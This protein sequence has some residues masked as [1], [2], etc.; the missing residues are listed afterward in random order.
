[1]H[2]K[3]AIYLTVLSVVIAGPV[4]VLLFIYPGFL[5]VPAHCDPSYEPSV[6]LSGHRFCAEMIPIA[7]PA[8]CE[9]IG[10]N[11]GGVGPTAYVVFFGIQFTANLSHPCTIGTPVGDWLQTTVVELNG[12]SY[13]FLERWLPAGSPGNW[14][15]PD[16]VAGFQ[17]LTEYNLTLVVASSPGH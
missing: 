12:S 4:I 16:G 15:T 6:N 7:P 9:R 10:T 5:I 2:S 8:R 3:R 11:Q 13:Q 14:T 17:W 1:M